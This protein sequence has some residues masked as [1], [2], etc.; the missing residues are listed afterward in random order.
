MPIWGDFEV[1]LQS[2]IGRGGM[3]TVYRGRQLS[4]NRPV[5]IKVLKADL[6][7]ESPEFVQRFNREAELLAK[8][9]DDHIVQVYFAGS[10]AGMYYY[11][12]EMV[13]GED[14]AR[15]IAKKAPLPDE[16]II[17]I[18]VDVC[19]ALEVA[20]RHGIVHR[21]IKPSNIYLT[22]N[23]KIKV[24]DFGLAKSVDMAAT[25]SNMVMGT[26][27]Y[28]SPEQAQGHECDIRSDLYS[29]GVVMY[30]LATG[31]PP[32]EATE[33]PVL[34]YKHL[35]E[36]P[37]SPRARNPEVSPGLEAVILR[38][39]AKRPEE[40]FQDPR[41]LRDA[42]DAILATTRRG[43]PLTPPNEPRSVG[44][45]LSLLGVLVGVCATLLF[46]HRDFWW[47]LGRT[48]T[49]F[50]G[51]RTTNRPP[52]LNGIEADPLR[53]ANEAY[54]AGEYA[55]AKKL[56]EEALP[57]INDQ[58]VAAAVQ[59]GIRNCDFEILMQRGNEYLR[60]QRWD[61]ASAVFQKAEQLRPGGEA[62]ALRRLAE[63]R[64]A[65]RRALELD[66]GEEWAEAAVQ[67]AHAAKLADPSEKDALQKNR[68]F[69]ERMNHALVALESARDPV[70]ARQ[71]VREALALRPRSNAALVLRDRVERE[72][73]LQATESERVRETERLLAESRR[74]R[75]SGD[76]RGALERL[77]AALLKA[78]DAY[79][80]TIAR[81]I[82][83]CR[84]EAHIK[85]GMEKLS[86]GKFDEAIFEFERA[87]G[88]NPGE[89]SRRW[90][91]RAEFERARAHAL[92]LE[93]AG[94]WGAA[95]DQFA[96]A[97]SK[98][99]GEDWKKRI[100]ESFGFCTLMAEGTRLL[101]VDKDPE[102]A[103]EKFRLA[104][105]LRP[106]HP[107]ALESLEAADRAL[108]KRREEQRARELTELL[109]AA[110]KLYEE[111]K[112]AESAALYER[113]WNLGYRREQFRRERHLARCA[114]APPEGMVFIP[115]GEFVMGG[116]AGREWEGP[117]H[118]LNLEPYYI[119]A[120]EVTQRKYAVFLAAIR[121]HSLCHPSEPKEK[122]SK[123]PQEAHTPLFWREQTQPDSP[124]TG[125]DWFDAWA[126]AAHAGK[127][128]PTE[129]EFEKAA[130]W[131]PIR[132]KKLPYPWGEA[133]GEGKG[134]SPAHCDGMGSGPI[135]WTDSAYL[136]Y[137]GA[138]E[139]PLYGKRFRVLRGGVYTLREKILD[140]R[141]FS[142]FH[143]SPTVRDRK[144]GFR[145]AMNLPPDRNE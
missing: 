21:D 43:P 64:Q 96:I 26:P 70:T 34:L 37:V 76:P 49:T 32:F 99:E 5:A 7:N 84:Y 140:S 94:E 112:W 75:D 10:V 66:R 141:T 72:A 9:I 138:K 123:P 92:A 139:N 17:R 46:V 82:G 124:V 12:M 119:D 3:S 35:H 144:A 125:V 98:A 13:T 59:Q 22:S 29:L 130:G 36:A 56:W 113:A 18:A 129:A 77:E 108:R 127:R 30:E 47:S 87:A 2:V 48:E 50:G 131:D 63:C 90:L 61:Q 74:L 115:A 105:D 51:V 28:A 120:K 44:L 101:N 78:P 58:H 39:L 116:N 86:G 62:A 11:A 133:Y 81:Q 67:Y 88:L 93:T 15:I 109:A 54:A 14:L 16:E 114:A 25:R 104:A 97:L 100:Q 20:W 55:R 145:C 23:G 106:D 80:E 137:P 40:R 24:M 57:H 136:P 65:T 126:F 8:L 4:L 110:A 89:E 71:K 142:R 135:E 121:D 53:Q 42:L 117:E 6:V 41:A 60:E 118:R 33:V 107:R 111:G 95:A 91:V 1:D 31:K 103:Y 27:R 52:N 68:D 85:I 134:L 19:R 143:L 128:L 69:C 132:K 122:R 45:R 38:L 83:A 73:E 79:R 102:A